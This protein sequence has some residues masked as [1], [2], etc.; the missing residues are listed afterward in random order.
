MFPTF[1]KVSFAAR[2]SSAVLVER[3]VEPPW[4][5]FRTAPPVTRTSPLFSNVPVCRFLFRDRSPGVYENVLAVGLKSSAVCSSVNFSR[6]P[7]TTTYPFCSNAAGNNERP[8]FI[9]PV[10]RNVEPTGSYSSA[11]RRSPEALLPPAINTSPFW[12]RVA[13]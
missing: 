13:V 4:P 5:L 12:S 2:Y 7:M 8:A 9:E 6:P 10:R 1:V 3:P 11:N